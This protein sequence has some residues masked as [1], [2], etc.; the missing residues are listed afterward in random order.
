MASKNKPK[1]SGKEFRPTLFMSIHGIRTHAK[2]QKEFADAASRN[3][4]VATYDYG[5]YGFFRFL[6]PWRDRK[7]IDRFYKW[8]SDTINEKTNEVNIGR[9][10]RRPSLVAHSLGTLIACGAMLIYSDI[11]FDKIILCGSI[12]SSDFDW[13][14]L[15]ARDQVSKVRNEFGTSDRWPALS[16]FIRKSNGVA[17][18]QGFDWFDSAVQNVKMDSFRHSDFQLKSHIQNFWLPFL[19]QRPSPLYTLHGRDIKDRDLFSTTLDHTG[20]VIDEQ[21]FGSLPNYASVEIERG[22]SLRWISINPDIYTFLIDRDTRNPVGYINAMPV[23][24]AIYGRIRAGLVSDNEVEETDLVPFDNDQ[25]VRIYLMSIAIDENYRNCGEGL[26]DT[27]YVQLVTAFLYKLIFY[28]KNKRT[29]VTHLLATAWTPQGIKVCQL[30]G[31]NE[32]G[33]DRFNDPIYEVEIDKVDVKSKRVMPALRS[34][35][36]LY[37]E[38]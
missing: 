16:R 5:Y 10:D 34:L 1:Q 24:D 3:T 11:V 13:G 8:Y 30:L 29:R 17:G 33:R 37:K 35:A 27:P 31:M 18:R 15:F 36:C 12:L 22:R 19:R 6:M 2:W 21:V 25:A 23:E 4:K 32:V 20:T 38:G 9:F 28:Y 7:Q 14:T 26:F